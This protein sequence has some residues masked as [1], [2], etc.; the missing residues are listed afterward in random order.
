MP[1]LED[2]PISVLIPTREREKQLH[3]SI[4]SMLLTCRRAERVEFLIAVDPDINHSVTVPGI[5]YCK[6]WTAPE[7]FGYSR[8]HEYFNGMAERASG[9]WLMLWNDDASMLTPR[10]DDKVMEQD[11]SQVLQPWHSGG[12]Y[13]HNDFPIWPKAWTDLIGY[14]SKVSCTDAWISH[15]GEL[16]KRTTQVDIKIKHDRPQHMIEA[17]L[18]TAEEGDLYDPKMVKLREENAARIIRAYQEGTLR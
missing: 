4:E 10:W 11:P 9:T 17:H 16:A 18:G 8:L 14:V 15:I 1:S 5:A 13:D 2:R 12:G 7:R 3:D 6:I